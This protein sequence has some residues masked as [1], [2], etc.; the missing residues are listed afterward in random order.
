MRIIFMGTPEFAV[1]SLECLI[2]NGYEVVGVYTQPDKAVGRGRVME[3]SPVKKAALRNNLK[4]L[5]PVNLKSVE[6]KTRL[7]EL[8]PDAI[9]V[10]A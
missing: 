2:S 5:Q 6:T 8:K 1:P 9:V 4:V 7:S 3:E 10:A